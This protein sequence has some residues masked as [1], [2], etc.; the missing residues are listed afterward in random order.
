[1]TPTYY[2]YFTSATIITSV[3]LFRG[4][5]GT[6]VAII[7]VV[8]G[9]LVICSGVVLLQLSKSAKDVPD[10]AVFNGDLDQMRTVA[11]QAEP[12]T[13][14]KAD[15]IRG[16]AAIIRRI[17]QSRQKMEAMEA[18]KIH[19]ERMEPIHENEHVEWDG[20]RRRKTV[21]ESSNGLQRQKTLHPPLGMTHFPDDMDDPDRPASSDIHGGAG[22]FHGNFFDSFRRR[23]QRTDSLPSHS[24][25]LNT[26]P[27]HGEVTQ[28]PP[29]PL[30]EVVT[31][32]PKGAEFGSKNSGDLG[33]VELTHVYGLPSSLQRQGSED[34]SGLK[35]IAWAD[36]I[37][38]PQ[39]LQREA[40]ER[41]HESL[42]PLSPSSRRQFSFQN[43]FSRNRASSATSAISSETPSDI[44]AMPADAKS[45]AT[46]FKKRKATSRNTHAPTPTEEERLGL[47]K[48]DGNAVP[49]THGLDEDIDH[50]DDDYWGLDRPSSPLQSASR[51]QPDPGISTEDQYT[52]VRNGSTKSGIPAFI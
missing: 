7:T 17:S 6:V 25:S 16:T 13:E 28:L 49:P 38:E 19:E 44:P 52:N 15:A 34:R 48:G 39:R 50:V 36:G 41:E 26:R 18:K 8:F 5:A 33:A 43:P 47:V 23:N 37:D 10:T 24:R 12:E 40:S 4:F 14:P 42:V 2:V 11:E 1:M 32:T 51:R 21:L 31:A 9:F 29:R 46:S 22:I 3:V 35:P 45:R 30:T 27:R 20:L